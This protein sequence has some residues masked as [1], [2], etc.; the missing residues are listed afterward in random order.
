MKLA[1]IGAATGQ[2]ALCQKANEMGIETIGFAWEEGAVCKDL[3]SKFYP[4]SIYEMD[5]I[6]EIC[7]QEKIDGIV[8]NTSEKTI[9]V[10]SYV[11]DAL[12]LHGGPYEV[13]QNIKNKPYTREQ[14]NKVQGITP[15]DFYLYDKAEPEPKFLPCIVKPCTAGAKRG[16]SFVETKEQFDEAI[17][18]AQRESK[19]GIL[20]EAFADGAELS[21]ES[22]SFEG[23][24]QVLQITD[25][26]N[27]G[28]PHFVEISHHQPSQMPQNIQDRIRNVVPSL[29][30]AVGFMDGPTHTELKIGSNGEIFLIEI[31]PRGGGDE[32]SNTLVELSC[33]RDYVK[34]M[35]EVALGTFEFKEVHNTGYA[36]IYF[37][38]KQT[39]YLA[40][41]FESAEGKPWLLRK[42]L[43]NTILNEAIGNRSRNGYLIYKANKKITP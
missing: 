32:I 43:S 15:I 41:F 7:Q 35:I 29:L 24:H 34:A 16:V 14:T 12:K 40:P 11:A 36:G 8:S 18:Y 2:K 10:V 27:T 30:K 19:N 26:E 28:A 4:I 42:Q 39:E 3:F 6:A 17:A 9:D 23:K 20:I 13:I 31:N 25:K 22:I 33:D 21:V 37:L 5:K 38:C 1:I